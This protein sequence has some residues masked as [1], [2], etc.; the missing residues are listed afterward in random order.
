MTPFGPPSPPRPPRP[1]RLPPLGPLGWLLAALGLGAIVAGAAAI[2]ALVLLGLLLAPLVVWLSWNV[3]D[4]AHA[5]GAPELGLWGILLLTL[6]LVAGFG[7]R[8][9]IALIVALV[10]PAWLSGSARLRWPE[11][12]V[13]TFVALALLLAVASLP[14]QRG[15]GGERGRKGGE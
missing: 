15:R 8:L 1:P 5:I 3:L 12:S 13:R 9:L 2:A 4:F 11:P 10:D 14:R 6:F 7:G